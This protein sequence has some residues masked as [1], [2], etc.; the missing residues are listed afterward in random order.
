M[1][2]CVMCVEM[3]G[4][5]GPTREGGRGVGGFTPEA[6]GIG[7]GAWEGGAVWPSLATPGVERRKSGAVKPDNL[8]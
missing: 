2:S 5:V 7:V 3:P 1:R 6:R 4:C 8:L